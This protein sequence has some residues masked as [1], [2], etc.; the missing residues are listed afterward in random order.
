M[1]NN[2]YVIELNGSTKSKRTLYEIRVVESL[3]RNQ[4]IVSDAADIVHTTT[5][6]VFTSNKSTPFPTFVSIELEHVPTQTNDVH[7]SLLR[8]RLR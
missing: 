7:F 6:S 4:K 8:V 2:V 3:V 5:V 1:S